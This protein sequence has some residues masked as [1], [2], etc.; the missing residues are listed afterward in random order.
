MINFHFLE[1]QEWESMTHKPYLGD[2]CR[3]IDSDGMIISA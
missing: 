2:F 1:I 3:D